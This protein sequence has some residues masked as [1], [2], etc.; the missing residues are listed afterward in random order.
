MS[1]IT[2]VKN[3]ICI[4]VIIVE[5]EPDPSIPH[6]SLFFPASFPARFSQ[7][8]P[9]ASD[10]CALSTLH[11][12]F[13]GC[14]DIYFRGQNTLFL[15]T[16]H[17]ISTS[18]FCY[19]WDEFSGAFGTLH[20]PSFGCGS[21]NLYA[22]VLELICKIHRCTTSSCVYVSNEICVRCGHEYFDVT[23]LQ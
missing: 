10:E 3:I 11:P 4:I 9:A 15:V 20:K 6:G 12:S 8:S 18:S 17:N 23:L 16:K 1:N 22:T 7:C 19:G 14:L 13:R 2:C 5:T 21:A